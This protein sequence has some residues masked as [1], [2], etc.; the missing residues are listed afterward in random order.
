MPHKI[1]AANADMR[2]YMQKSRDQLKLK[3]ACV[4]FSAFVAALAALAFVAGELIGAL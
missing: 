3:T 2:N 1:L 4:E